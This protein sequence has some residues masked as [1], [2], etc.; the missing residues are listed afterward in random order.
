VICCPVHE[1]REARESGKICR[2]NRQGLLL[3]AAENADLLSPTPMKSLASSQIPSLSFKSGIL[4]LLLSATLSETNKESRKMKFGPP[5]KCV[6]RNIQA[7][8]PALDSLGTAE[9]YE[10]AFGEGTET[11]TA[12]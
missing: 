8:T 9:G 6:G 11:M 7:I 5:E 10:T 4:S 12:L 2:F 1:Q 3:V